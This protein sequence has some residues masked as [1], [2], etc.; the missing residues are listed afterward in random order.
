MVAMIVTLQDI[1]KAFADLESGS[2]S[3][4]EIASY[5]SSAMRADDA[6]SLRMEPSA[7]SPIIWRAI[8]Y[9]TGVDIKEP[10]ESYLHCIEDFVEFRKSIGLPT[11]S[12]TPTEQKNES[13]Q[14]SSSEQRP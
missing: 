8:I 4:E 9:L 13:A 5:A 1:Q 3:R 2:R 12:T 14:T 6:N 11:A 7:D 10:P